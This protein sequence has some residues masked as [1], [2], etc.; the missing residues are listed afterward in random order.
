MPTPRVCTSVSKQHTVLLAATVA[1]ALVAVAMVFPLVEYVLAAALLAYV[2]YP[3]HRRLSRRTDERLS[4]ALLL[5]VSVVAVVVPVGLVLGVALREA[6]R[7]REALLAGEFGLRELD[8]LAAAGG[9]DLRGELQELTRQELG[10]G[11]GT[12]LGLFGGVTEVLVG[13]TVL[14]FV[15]YYLLKDGDRLLAWVTAVVPVDPA[16]QASLRRD[17][18]RITWGVVVGNVAVALVQGVLTG[19]VFLLVGVD[20]VVFWVV[21]TTLLSLLPMI[22]ASVV[23][24]PMSVFL[25]V[26]GRPV[27]AVV[28]FVLGAAVISLSDNYLRPIITGREAHVSPGLMVLGIFGGVLTVGFVGLFVGPIALAFLKSLV[29]TLAAE[30]PSPPA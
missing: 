26:T 24:L 30:P 25:A 21:V 27:D 9:F 11:L 2:L 1:V 3:I 15:V 5:A 17:L 16:V 10:A 29:E 6:M 8:A 23:W 28:V 13:L 4:A 18:D 19:L 12:L 20:N 14:L 22:G 7:V